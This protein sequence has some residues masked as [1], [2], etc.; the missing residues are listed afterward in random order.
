MKRKSLIITFASQKKKH[1]DED[2]FA[3]VMTLAGFDVE[4]YRNNFF[5]IPVCPLNIESYDNITIFPW[6]NALWNSK[7]N[8]AS[9]L[10]NII[11]R[12]KPEALTVIMNDTSI[13]ID[14]KLWD[15]TPNKESINKK[16]ILKLKPLKIIG[17][18]EKECLK[19]EAAMKIITKKWISVCHPDS[20]FHCIQW[21]AGHILVDKPHI[22][23]KNIK[24][25]INLFNASDEINM[26]YYGI[27]K[28]TIVESLKRVGIGN[29][30]NDA[31][32]GPI[33]KNFP[34]IRNLTNK[35]NNWQQYVMK[36][37]INIFP[38]DFPKTNYQITP[39][40]IELIKLNPNSILIDPKITGITKEITTLKQIEEKAYEAAN[41]LKEL[42]IK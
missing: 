24:T 11:N 4:I 12:A 20:T 19:D 42:F 7:A 25:E 35:E 39:R 17:T 28:T 23:P 38:Y 32:F 1:M 15:E 37:K 6:G 3:A 41:D 40:M 34:N 8:R 5:N 33:A 30:E 29:N 18:M 22:N 9:C 27:N 36:A 14:P 13:Q 16:D 31:L 21:N 10:E 26:F 2:A